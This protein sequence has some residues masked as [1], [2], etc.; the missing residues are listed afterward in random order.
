MT[1]RSFQTALPIVTALLWCPSLTL[2]QGTTPPHW[3]VDQNTCDPQN[4]DGSFAHPF[5]KIQDA[6]SNP[7]MVPNSPPTLPHTIWVIGTDSQGTVVPYTGPGNKDLAMNNGRLIHLLSMSVNPEKCVIDCQGSGRG[8]NLIS[9][10][11]SGVVIEGFTIRNGNGIPTP[12]LSNDDRNG[13]GIRVHQ[14]SPTIRGNVIENCTASAR[15]GGGIYCFAS[16]GGDRGK[17]H[18]KQP[19]AGER[20]RIGR[21]DLR[22][23]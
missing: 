20:D 9:G 23:R 12:P 15:V 1:H 14:C 18:P 5:C 16:G 6:I 17:P 7:A 2:A 21:R 3:W 13:G 8:F 22:Q 4:A 10:T 19:G 11:N